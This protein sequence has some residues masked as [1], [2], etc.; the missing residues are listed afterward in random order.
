MNSQDQRQVALLKAINVVGN[1]KQLA[2]LLTT[3]NKKVR[4]QNVQSWIK[5]GFVPAEHVLRIEHFTGV[6]RFELRPDVFCI[7]SDLLTA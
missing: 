1:Q 4:Q 5:R 2:D 7:P 3:H 6:T